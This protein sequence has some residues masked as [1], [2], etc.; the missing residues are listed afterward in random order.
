MDN[1]NL[2]DSI[3]HSNNND[4]VDKTLL[5]EKQ[6]TSRTVEEGIRVEKFKEP[7]HDTKNVLIANENMDH[8]EISTH[9]IKEF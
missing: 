1:K 2:L 9:M 5:L 8:N 7:V 6:N 4:N 3:Q